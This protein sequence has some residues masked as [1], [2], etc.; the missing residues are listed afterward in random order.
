MIIS[1]F[2][3]RVQSVGRGGS[4]LTVLDDTLRGSVEV[5]LWPGRGGVVPPVMPGC[6]VRLLV[7]DVSVYRGRVQFVAF[8]D[9][10]EI[11]SNEDA[12]APVA[13][14]LPDVGVRTGDFV[15]DG[16]EVR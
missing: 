8:S 13:D 16:L 2:V 11:L 15:P 4:V 7:R 9:T 6:R 14:F 1:G 10:V 5:S 3:G 12:G